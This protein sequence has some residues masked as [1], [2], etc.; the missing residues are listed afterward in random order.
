LNEVLSASAR[1]WESPRHLSIRSKDPKEYI[2]TLEV[3]YR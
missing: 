3:C 1:A 2:I